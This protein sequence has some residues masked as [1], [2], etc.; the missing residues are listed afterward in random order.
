LTPENTIIFHVSG[1]QVGSFFD[2]NN[3]VTKKEGEAE[4]ILIKKDYVGMLVCTK[5]GLI[6]DYDLKVNTKGFYYTNFNE[7][8]ETPY[9][10]SYKLLIK[11]KISKENILKQ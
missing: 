11:N 5:Q 1:N 7:Y 4:F 3:I 2:K 9:N 6:L 10:Q 8:R